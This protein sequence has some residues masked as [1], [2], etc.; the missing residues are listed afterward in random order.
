MNFKN[1]NN[2]KDV[3]MSDV[4]RRHILTVA[5]ILS[6][7]VLMPGLSMARIA[8][9]IFSPMANIMLDLYDCY[10]SSKNNSI[11]GP[12]MGE[13]TGE[14]N[15]KLMSTMSFCE[16]SNPAFADIEFYINNV[17]REQ[18]YTNSDIILCS[19][20]VDPVTHKPC[21][22]LDNNSYIKFIYT[23]NNDHNHNNDNNSVNNKDRLNDDNSVNNKDRVNEYE[24]TI[25]YTIEVID[26]KNSSYLS[27]TCTY[28][29]YCDDKQAI[30]N[31]CD[32]CKKYKAEVIANCK[33]YAV[34][35]Y[36]SN[37]KDSKLD[38]W[39]KYEISIPKTFDNLFLS[40]EISKFLPDMIHRFYTCKSNNQFTGQT[41]K[42]S[43]LFSGEPGC[44]KSTFA[45]AL[46]NQ[47]KKN[48]T[49]IGPDFFDN[50]SFYKIFRTITNCIIVI[51][52]IDTI[53][54]FLKRNNSNIDK[55]SLSLSVTDEDY[56]DIIENINS[57]DDSYNDNAG[58]SGVND[59][60]GSMSNIKPKSKTDTMTSLCKKIIGTERL[61]QM[62][63]MLD[64]LDGYCF[65]KGCVV[66]MTTNHP[67]KIDPAFTRSGRC[68]HHIVFK[69]ADEYQIRNIF[70]YFYKGWD[71][72][73]PIVNH[74]LANNI[75]TSYIISTLI[76]PHQFTSPH[77]ALTAY[78]R[79]YPNFVMNW[80]NT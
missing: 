12:D 71:V 28:V 46:A 8:M 69:P 4:F 37:I 29:I 53:P 47:Y 27:Y 62:N 66:I 10:I 22:K 56:D 73:T 24:I 77:D 20:G 2:N 40:K 74:M 55:S 45:Y 36:N 15:L 72:P 33:D 80:L 14:Y 23:N 75:K 44:G 76:A 67:E 61:A 58:N 59:N 38:K 21:I 31:F 52:E 39:E 5:T 48:I 51:E 63:D 30:I 32:M 35:R 57:D 49:R 65:L 6:Q 19:D 11:E 17:I 3:K 68:D 79:D 7:I 1:D 54:L 13:I 50:E 42:I 18:T 16:H 41:N 25:L 43:F 34:Y 26:N 70:K 64:V 9:I 60:T 78:K